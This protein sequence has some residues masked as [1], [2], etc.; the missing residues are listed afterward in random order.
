MEAWIEEQNRA[1]AGAPWEVYWTGPE[2]V[3]EPDQW[4]TE[5]VWPV[6]SIE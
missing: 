5:V 4:K 6:Y 3:P 2:E 1:P